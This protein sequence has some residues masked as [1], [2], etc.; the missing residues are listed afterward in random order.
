L[1]IAGYLENIFQQQASKM[2]VAPAQYGAG[3][4]I[5]NA[6]ETGLKSR[7]DPWLRQFERRVE[8]AGNKLGLTKDQVMRRFLKGEI[9]LS[10]LLGGII[11]GGALMGAGAD[12]ESAGASTE[13]T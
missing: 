4:F 7:P 8:L 11:A 12:S 9:P 5:G 6:A 13:A 10:L 1:S 2:G 3:T